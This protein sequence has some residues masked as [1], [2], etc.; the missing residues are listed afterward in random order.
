MAGGD[1]GSSG[2]N[3]LA[4]VSVVVALMSLGASILQNVNYA[5]SIDSVQRNVL[6][7][8]SLRSCKDIIAV[9][10]EFRLK[11]EAANMSGEGGMTSIELKGL[12][13]R[14]GALGT[15]LANFQEQPSRDR[16][17]ALAWHLNRIA[18]E[19][20]KLPKAEFDALFNE[21]D[22]QFGAIN[23]DCVKAATG[24]LL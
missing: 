9:F 14:F 24:H 17:S 4:M 18:G 8:E 20:A 22:K 1:S 23:D 10:F 5:R 11:A 3:R 13:Y 7:A 6:R 16:Y 2:S 15:F 21:A 19:G 12:A